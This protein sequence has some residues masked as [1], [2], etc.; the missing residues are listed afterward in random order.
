MEIFFAS[1]DKYAQHLGVTIASILINSDYTDKL[2][3]HILESGIS[4]ENKDNIEFL[5]S[6]RTFNIDYTMMEFSEAFPKFLHVSQDSYSRLK[7]PEL[8]PYI[9]KAL[10]L[11]CDIV[12]RSSLKALWDTDFCGYPIAAALDIL[13]YAAHQNEFCAHRI[14]IITGALE[15][16]YFNAG[17]M[18]LNLEKLRGF[19]LTSKF[20][21]YATNHK[22]NLRYG[23]QD[24]LNGVFVN[25]V[26]FIGPEWNY[27]ARFGN[28]FQNINPKIIHFTTEKKPWITSEVA[29]Y[30]EYAKYLRLT[31]WAI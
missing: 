17:V 6:I 22:E 26:K 31:P 25:N 24:I 1:N 2:N 19:D 8:F 29:F 10:Y 21:D 4:D 9:D 28:N 13:N 20:I 5:K 18:L 30:E 3:F 23:D 15:N 12:V 27:D 7:I 14:K 11:D 16:Y